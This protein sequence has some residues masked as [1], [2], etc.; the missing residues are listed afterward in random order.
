MERSVNER[1]QNT[2][3]HPLPGG[4]FQVPHTVPAR[5]SG[6]RYAVA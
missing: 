6:G 1:S 5:V 3:A 4:L 2:K